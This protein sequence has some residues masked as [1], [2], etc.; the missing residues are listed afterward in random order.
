MAGGAPAECVKRLRRAVDAG[1]AATIARE[2]E[3]L[4]DLALAAGTA[5][6]LDASLMA[7]GSAAPLLESGAPGTVRR[8]ADMVV[9]LSEPFYDG[10]FDDFMEVAEGARHCALHPLM[11][12]AVK[13]GDVET[14][15]AIRRA[16]DEANERC[17][18]R[19]VRESIP[20]SPGSHA[21][22]RTAYGTRQLIELLVER[23]DNAAVPALLTVLQALV[24]RPLPDT[25]NEARDAFGHEEAGALAAV[26]ASPSPAQLADRCMARRKALRALATP[27]KDWPRTIAALEPGST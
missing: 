12:A 22:Y 23:N 24:E 3:T 14:A 10:L 26:L 19:W 16:E 8:F 1:D 25:D 11:G 27:P 9:R 20:T 5:A 15:L 21:L 4:H 7:I 2:I 6:R 17:Y 13:A 18:E